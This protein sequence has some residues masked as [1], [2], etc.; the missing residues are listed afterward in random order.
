MKDLDRIFKD[1]NKIFEDTDRAFK[2]VD[3]DMNR[4]FNDMDRIFKQAEKVM[5]ETFVATE[6]K[7]EP[8]QKW[9]AWHPVTIKG[10]RRWMKTVYRRTKLKFGDQRLTHEW[11]YGDMFDVLKEAGH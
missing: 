11:E 6:A 3:A 5:N 1:M 7:P 9:F 4:V 8:W 10:R 2:K